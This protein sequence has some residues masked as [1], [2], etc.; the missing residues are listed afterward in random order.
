[1]EA[2]AR[3]DA[4]I[5]AVVMVIAGGKLGSTR[6]PEVWMLGRR[7]SGGGEEPWCR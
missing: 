3:T 7:D 6:V 2:V 4:V 1:M 5:V